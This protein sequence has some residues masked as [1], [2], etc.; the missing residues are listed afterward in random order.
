M[1]GSH[2]LYTT[3][4]FFFLIA[5]SANIYSQAP[6][7]AQQRAGWKSEDQILYD[8]QKQKGTQ[9]TPYRSPAY[10]PSKSSGSTEHSGTDNAPA[11]VA[12]SEAPMPY[13]GFETYR[14][15][16]GEKYIG[17]F[18]NSARNGT[19]TLLS[20]KGDTIYS[21]EWKD[22]FYEGTGTLVALYSNDGKYTGEFKH[23]E[24][25][26]L[27]TIK[28]RT[29]NA[30]TGYWEKDKMNG[31]GTYTWP[32]GKKFVGT[33]KD[34]ERNGPGTLYDNTGKKTLEGT[35]FKD[36]YLTDLPE[37]VLNDGTKCYGT[38]K[39]G[40][41]WGTGVYTYANGD[42]YSGNFENGQLNG[43]GW[44][45]GANGNS[46]EGEYLNGKKEGHGIFHYEHATYIGDFKNGKRAGKGTFTNDADNVWSGEWADDVLTGQ[47]TYTGKNGEKYTG[48]FVDGIRE[49]KGLRIMPSGAH[50]EGDW[51]EGKMNGHGTWSSA[52]GS[53]Y[54]GEWAD[55]KLSGQGVFT[56]T[57]GGKYTGDFA[58]GDFN[59]K[60]MYVFFDGTRY[61]GEWKNGKRN[62][63]GIFY[64]KAG[65]IVQQGTWKN[66][67][68]MDLNIGGLDE[69]RHLVDLA[70]DNF[71]HAKGELLKVDKFK[72]T[73]Y[74]TY[75]SLYKV[76]P[77]TGATATDIS[78]FDFDDGIVFKEKLIFEKT[79]ERNRYCEELKQILNLFSASADNGSYQL[80]SNPQVRLSIEKIEPNALSIGLNKY[81]KK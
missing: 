52:K 31:K 67:L 32:D 44:F 35:W 66:D 37:H 23:G 30:Y 13:S 2:R 76:T 48:A 72:H 65:S 70:V 25:N 21:G 49:G 45:K 39:D 29:G 36:N 81:P 1:Q 51:K 10:P 20:V 11:Y 42:I 56:D 15:L 46:Y 73:E 71:K 60:G 78:L 47:G 4:C 74:K 28:Q 18:Q 38:L 8:L 63:E 69:L 55:G 41:L 27:G 79:S 54:K 50:F 61:D 17:N 7:A 5:L 14:F 58:D 26:G 43:K 75:A 53:T 22:N 6:N 16:N 33:F 12:P 57:A 62:G 19:G 68:L 9:Y 3:G 64:N 77:P 34:D 24:K 59:G 80:I 40:K